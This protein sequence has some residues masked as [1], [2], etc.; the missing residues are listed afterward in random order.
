MTKKNKTFLLLWTLGILAYPALDFAQ[1]P[2][3][4]FTPA[5]PVN[6]VVDFR[7]QLQQQFQSNW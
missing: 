1:T 5:P 6:D 4:T 2:T 3:F 7:I